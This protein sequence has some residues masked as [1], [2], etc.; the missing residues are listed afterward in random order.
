MMLRLSY[1]IIN[2]QRY[3][4]D[5]IRKRINTQLCRRQLSF[6]TY[7]RLCQNDHGKKTTFFHTYKNDYES[8][9]KGKKSQLHRPIHGAFTKTSTSSS[10]RRRSASSLKMIV[11][12]ERDCVDVNM[13][14]TRVHLNWAT[15]VIPGTDPDRPQKVCQDGHFNHRFCLSGASSTTSKTIPDS[16]NLPDKVPERNEHSSQQQWYTVMGIM[17]GHGLK[18]HIL[19]RFLCD[20]LPKRIEECMNRNLCFYAN[21]RNEEIDPQTSLI[22]EEIEGKLISLGGAHIDELFSPIFAMQQKGANEKNQRQEIDE[23]ES[24]MNSNKYVLNCCI[25]RAL[26][27]AF[28]LAHHDARVDPSIPAGRSGTTCIVTV[29]DES[30]QMMYVAN[31]GD[32]RAIYCMTG[33]SANEGRN[34]DSNSDINSMTCSSSSSSNN[35]TVIPL[36]NE[37]TTSIPKELER[38]SAKEGRIDGSGN[39]FYGPVGIAMTRALGDAVMLRAGVLPTPI[40][41][42]FDLWGNDVTRDPRNHESD[43]LERDRLEDAKSKEGAPTI[44]NDDHNLLRCVVMATDGIFD[45]MKNEDVSNILQNT[46]EDSDERIHKR[47]KEGFS[48]TSIVPNNANHTQLAEIFANQIAVAARERWGADLP[49]D[50]K[51]DDITCMVLLITEDNN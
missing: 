15:K 1:G 32:S 20:I 12:N 26:V 25:Q 21:S 17:D 22:I 48:E 51:A 7:C 14:A 5:N 24:S 41:R 31:V 27:E 45:V 47:Y 16:D 43:I 19:T 23:I 40:V 38:V 11:S 44:I 33:A 9:E 36:T 50:V 4:N 39:V 34:I 18:G 2:F 13:R 49:L 35:Y 28:H 42:V 6:L 30:N 46:L 29:V 37:T 3:N 8:Y 10:L